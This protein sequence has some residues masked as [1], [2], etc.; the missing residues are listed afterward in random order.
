VRDQDSR[1]AR[2]AE[3]D[4]PHQP[5]VHPGAPDSPSFWFAHTYLPLRLPQPAPIQGSLQAER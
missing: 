1:V 4:V 3:K 2:D 5:I